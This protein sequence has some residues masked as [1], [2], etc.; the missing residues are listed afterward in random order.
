MNDAA[1]DLAAKIA[2]AERERTVWA[3][4]RK[5][6]RAGG[7]AALNPHSLRSP[8]HALWAEGFEAEREATKAPVWSE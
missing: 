2:A 1:K 6:F 4:G 3:E 8:D 5:V 7:P